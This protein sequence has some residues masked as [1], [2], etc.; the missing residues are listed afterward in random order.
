MELSKGFNWTTKSAGPNRQRWQCF[1]IFGGDSRFRNGGQ[2]S[3]SS[4]L[5][6]SATQCMD[7]EYQD[8]SR[9]NMILTRLLGILVE[10]E[11]E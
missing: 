10:V 9:H 4:K 2:R 8:R 1:L 7:G 6:K 5:S 11:P 3:A